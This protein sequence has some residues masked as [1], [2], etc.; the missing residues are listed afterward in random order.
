MALDRTQ[1]RAILIA[2]LVGLLG[3]MVYMGWGRNPAYFSQRPYLRCPEG[4][5]LFQSDSFGYTLCL[6]GAWDGNYVTEN[7]DK[8]ISFIHAR[9]NQKTPL[10]SIVMIPESFWTESEDLRRN[11]EFVGRD[12]GRV[13][14]ALRGENVP[15]DAEITAF[16]N[17]IPEI[18]R[19]ISFSPNKSI[20]RVIED[21]FAAEIAIRS[22]GGKI[23]TGTEILGRDEENGQFKYYVWVHAQEYLLREGQLDKGKVMNLPAVFTVRPQTVGHAVVG[24]QAPRGGEFFNSDVARLF[25]ERIGKSEWFN[26]DLVYHDQHVGILN[27]I[28]RSKARAE[29]GIKAE[30]KIG[31]IR[32]V[33]AE[34]GVQKIVLDPV[35][36][37]MGQEAVIA[38]RAEGA[39]EPLGQCVP[40]N[41]VYISNPDKGTETY[42]VAWSPEVILRT[43]ERPAYSEFLTKFLT[44]TKT[45]EDKI[46]YFEIENGKIVKISEQDAP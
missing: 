34:D 6:P 21:Y 5:Q 44:D 26:A 20:D 3:Y 38:M 27:N 45:F 42:E 43:N 16:M 23:F 13:F 29:Y 30:R 8:T 37:L 10:F 7:R 40:L 32:T 25:P 31:Y 39:C 19:S 2:V 18:L 28:V 12:D 9:P 33:S 17:S 1:L 14:A 46:F 11:M 36:W 41:N 15:A 24:F 4:T 35:F 22:R